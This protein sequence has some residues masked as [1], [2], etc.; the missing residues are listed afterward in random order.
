[1]S[2]SLSILKGEIKRLGFVLN[3]KISLFGY[4]TGNEKNQT[5]ALSL[6]DDCDSDEEKRNYLRSLVSL[7][8]QYIEEIRVLRYELFLSKTDNTRKSSSVYNYVKEHGDVQTWE[9]MEDKDI[10]IELELGRR[11][12]AKHL[13]APIQG[14]N[15]ITVNQ[16]FC[17]NVVNEIVN[18]LYLG[19]ELLVLGD[20]SGRE[21]DK[22]YADIIIGHTNY[23]REL[24]N[25]PPD[26]SKGLGWE[27][28]NDLTN[29]TK[30]KE[31]KGQ[32]I[33]YARK[34]LTAKSP[35][36]DVFYG[37]LTD[38]KLWKF[39]KIQL[40]I[41]DN[42]TPKMK[43]HLILELEECIVFLA[44]VHDYEIKDTVLKIEVRKD[45]EIS[46]VYHE[47]SALQA[48]GDL[49]CIPKILFEGY[50]REGYLALLTDFAGQLLESWIS[51][52]GNIDDYTIF[53]IILDLLSCLEK[54]HASGYTHGDVAIRN[55]IQRNGH[56][57]L[58][59]FGL[60]TLL[61]L[62]SDPCQAIIQD[63]GRLCQIIGII[64]FGKKMSLLK[65][66]DKLKGELRL[67]VESVRMQV[68]GK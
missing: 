7:P 29:N 49:S 34:Y 48:L 38:G 51:D 61:Q 46:Q 53:Q 32:L 65:L 5:D 44:Q 28:K 17:K 42:G 3:E 25:S 63:Y 20:Y 66:I 68:S 37:C 39:T 36:S 60:A 54:I 41:D 30:V 56:F 16:P 62:Y 24:T 43:L 35:Q 50:T 15:E 10:Y 14:S 11:V 18:T 19:A 23:C 27:V 13:D 26:L 59:D 21:E 2:D 52:N 8:E 22:I 58:I 4:F 1:M 9:I 55:V 31:G 57:Y 33:K 12:F 45:T 47:I 67:F 64:K 40:L 6:L